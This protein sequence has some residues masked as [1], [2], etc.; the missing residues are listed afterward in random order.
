VR[1]GIKTELQEH[2]ASESPPKLRHRAEQLYSWFTRAEDVG[3][4]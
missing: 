1:E 4:S 3:P 2:Y